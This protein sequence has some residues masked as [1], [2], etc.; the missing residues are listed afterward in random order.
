MFFMVA[1]H[2]KVC[3]FVRAQQTECIMQFKNSLKHILTALLFII[4]FAVYAH[5]HSFIDVQATIKIDSKGINQI[6]F[7]WTQNDPFGDNMNSYEPRQ[8]VDWCRMWLDEHIVNDNYCC[9][10]FVNNRKIAANKFILKQVKLLQEENRILFNIILNVT[11]PVKDKPV[12]V[13]IL[14]EDDDYYV[15]FSWLKD[16]IG[17]SGGKNLIRNVKLVNDNQ[18][19]HFGIVPPAC[20]IDKTSEI[21]SSAHKS[22]K[23][24]PGGFLK[25]QVDWNRK[26]HHYLQKLK[27]EYRWSTFLLLFAAASAYGVFHA[28]GPGHGKGLIA[29]YFLSGGHSVTDIIKIT[30]LVTLLHTGTAFILVLFFYFSINIVPPYLRVKVQSYLSFALALAVIVLGGFMLAN[31]LRRKADARALPKNDKNLLWLAGIFPCPQSIVIMLGCI[32]AGIWQIGVFLVLGISLGTFAVLVTVA[33][34]CYC[35]SKSIPAFLNRKQINHKYLYSF[36]E[37]LK[38]ALIIFSGGILALLNWP[39]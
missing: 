36:L 17:F 8:Y 27:K 39:T 29:A 2:Y 25:E 21:T 11:I 28:A 6:D 10:V 26:I 12:T 24:L 13:D 22:G 37:W 31:S 35:S 14:M 30:L 4:C 19:L 7:L 15:A 9:S 23:L 3:Y 5:P 20:K 16:K 33:G 18:T 1:A 38:C 32:A 34:I